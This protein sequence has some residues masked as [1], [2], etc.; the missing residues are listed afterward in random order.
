M[1]GHTLEW[2]RYQQRDSSV[3]HAWFFAVLGC[4][5]LSQPVFKLIQLLYYNSTAYSIG[6]GTG[7][8]LFKVLAGVRTGCPLSATLVLL[9]MNPFVELINRLCDA[10][11]LWRTCVCADDIGSALKSLDTLRIQHSIF[12][13]AA[14][15]A[16]MHLKPSKC[17]IIV[18]CVQL[19]P[20]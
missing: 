9:A 16:N 10:P 2:C 3:A 6:I 11:N 13:L 18:S 8:F 4:I 5:E 1:I 20:D 19:T 15:V 12:R 17:F 14:R 7:H